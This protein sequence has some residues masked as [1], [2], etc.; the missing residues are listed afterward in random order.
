M[1][2]A[3][4]VPAFVL[5]LTLC[6]A[7]YGAQVR[8]PSGRAQ[9]LGA[10]A[11]CDGTAATVPGSW[12]DAVTSASGPES[13]CGAVRSH[14]RYARDVHPA[15]EWKS[16]TRTWVQGQGDCEDFAAA[17]VQMCRQ[18]GFDARVVVFRARAAGK[19]H[20]VALGVRDGRMWMSSNGSY[21]EVASF[22]EASRRVSQLCGWEG[23]DVTRQ[24][25]GG[26]VAATASACGEG[27]LYGVPV[28]G[29]ESHVRWP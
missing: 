22:D 1:A 25:V 21:E 6:A 12:L 7:A 16:G 4:Y 14:V 3:A 18:R 24:D 8:G 29:A 10:G 13:V 2:R 17:V 28:V 11:A 9:G 5:S 26:V 27:S 20:A 15:D 23:D 19:A